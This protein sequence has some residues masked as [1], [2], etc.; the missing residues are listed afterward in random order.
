MFLIK[1]I[2]APFF[3]PLSVC[4]ELM[5]LGLF[6]LWW[7]K[8]QRAGKILVTVGTGLL[9]LL[10]YHPAPDFLLRPLE[11]KYPSLTDLTEMSWQKNSIKWIVVLDGD[12]GAALS[13]VLEGVRLY[14]KIPGV[15]LLM[16]GGSVFGSEPGA[17]AS[18][19]VARIMGVKPQDLVLES[20]SR[21]T[22]EEARQIKNL[23][24]KDGLI[25]VTSASHMPRSIAMF[26]KIGLEPVPAPTGHMVKTR[27]NFVPGS[28]LPSAQNL[29]LAEMAVY[30]YLGLSW[31]WVRGLI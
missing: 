14:R 22:Q 8:R 23:V 27:S 18:V 31:A 25:L 2:V 11:Q 21:D 1:K 28:F 3:F 19:R 20:E 6:L 13:R 10:S 26:R 17:V 7:T 24:G 5:M 30:E 4:L 9:V 29:M 16:S 12:E 15:K